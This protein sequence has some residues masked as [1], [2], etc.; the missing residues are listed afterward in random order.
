[1]ISSL[2]SHLMED[3]VVAQ[4]FQYNI[5][6]VTN[7]GEGQSPVIRFSVTDPTNDDAPYDIAN[8]PPFTGPGT[9]LAMGISWPNT[10]FNNVGN[11]DGTTTTGRA[12]GQAANISIAGQGTGL[13]D[14][15]MANGDGTFTLDTALL[16]NPIAVP[17]TNPPLGSG[18]VVL[19]G[20]LAADFNRDDV[21]DDELP[22]TSAS[23]PFAI[24]DAT[25]NPR[26][27]VA[28]LVKCQACHGVNDGLS[29]HG[30]NRTDNIEVCASCHTADATDLFRRPVDPDGLA[31]GVNEAA[32]DG[33][34]DR[35]VDMKYMIHAI[36]AADMREEPYYV[37]GFGSNPFD[38]S[39]VTYPRS[40]ADCDAC[41]TGDTFS[42]PLDG[43]LA[44]TVN[45]NATVVGN[46]FFGANAFMPDDGSATD[47][48]DDNNFSPESAVCV[49]CH[50]DDVAKQ[51]MAV[52]SDSPISFGNG[53]LLN[54][55]PFGDPDTQDRIDMNAENCGFCHRPGGFV[56]VAEVHGL[57]D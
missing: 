56:D 21:Y 31:N 48:T 38:F 24:N 47:P 7:S 28:D 2:E 40:P 42:I 8:D 13:P 29:L 11:N 37:Y 35:T 55:D 6:Q 5:L 49:A 45:S 12:V 14:Y 30:N 1:M 19:E 3:A 43:V 33:I 26:R 50:D 46:S 25:A 9:R 22:V 54:P 57:L 39:E 52:R 15:I 4:Q 41:H 20:H 16:P 53:Y 17:S 10:D 51:H 34:E 23:S 32:A 44:T 27:V 36:H 18:T